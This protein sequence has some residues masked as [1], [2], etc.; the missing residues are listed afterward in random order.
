MVIYDVI[1]DSVIYKHNRP[2]NHRSVS[3]MN[4]VDLSYLG[5]VLAVKNP[6]ANAGDVRDGGSIPG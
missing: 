1:I 6:P 4:R 3:A 2:V 5:M